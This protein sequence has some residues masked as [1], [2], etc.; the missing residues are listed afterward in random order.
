MDIKH[1]YEDPDCLHAGTLPPRSIFKSFNV[2]DNHLCEKNLNGEW[3]FSF[4]GSIRLGREALTSGAFRKASDKV[5][6]PST[7]Q[8]TGYD[9]P[10]YINTRY[11]F[12][13]NP[14][15]VPKDNPMGIYERNIVIS[16]NE[17]KGSIILRFDGVDSCFFVHVNEEFVGYSQVSHSISEFDITDKLHEGTNLLT[18]TVLKWCDGSY[19]ECQDKF[20][21]T[22]IFRDVDL[23][24][25]P[26]DYL[27]DYTVSALPDETLTHGEFTLTTDKKYDYEIKCELAFEGSV[28]ASGIVD[29]DSLSLEIDN[30][31]LWNQEEPKLYELTITTPKEIIKDYV[32]FRRID[33]KGG[34]FYLNN[35]PCKLR[36]VNYHD[37]NPYEGARLSRTQVMAD[38]KLMREC[39]INAIRTSHY[40][41]PYWFMELADRYGFAL[42]DEADIETHGASYIYVDGEREVSAL[43]RS[44]MFRTAYLDRIKLLYERD[45]NHP[46]V[47]LWSLGNESGYGENLIEGAKYLHSKHDGR[48]VH[49]EGADREYRFTLPVDEMD[50]YSNMYASPERVNDYCNNNPER[51]RR[52]YMQCEFCHAM[53]NGPGD[54]HENVNQLFDYEHYFGAFVWEWCDHAVFDGVDEAGHERFLYGGDSGEAYHDGNFCMD[55]LVFPD[56]RVHTG[57]LEYKNVLRPI[58]L[59]AFNRTS[60][61]AT[62]ENRYDYADALSQVRILYELKDAGKT[63]STGEVDL[64][65]LTAWKP[66]EK[67]TLKILNAPLE[68]TQYIIF[69]Y[70]SARGFDLLNKGFEL[71][72]DEVEP[73]MIEPPVA[74]KGAVG[75]LTLRQSDY[76]FVI[77]GDDLCY[78][79]DRELGTFTKLGKNGK[80]LITRP[81]EFNVL[82]AYTDND[83]NVRPLWEK[84]GYN[85]MKFNVYETKAENVSD[86][87]VITF[88]GVLAAVHR[89]PAVTIFGT[90]TIG[91]DGSIT[92]KTN[93]T[94]NTSMEF[95][96]R[97]GLRLFIPKSFDRVK[98]F[99]YGPN[100]SYIDKH[101]SC[102][103]DLFEQGIDELSEPYVKPQETGSHFGTH[104]LTVRNNSD[105]LFVQAPASFSFNLSHYTAE[106]Q[107]KAAHLWELEN[108]PD[109]VLCLD[110]KMSGVG[111]NSCGPELPDCYR[112]NEETFNWEIKLTPI[113]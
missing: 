42:V 16:E 58:K 60:T 106:R 2:S 49:Y 67:V 11:P 103:L 98:Y 25:R 78:V 68:G 96:P 30:P 89:S 88:Y 40:P 80:K 39:N 110:Y 15:F 92:L 56:R 73:I 109:N 93:C 21:E 31:R 101:R 51:F 38:L 44:P 100:E 102:S 48:L 69:K 37:S 17:L 35:V 107:N 82:R 83:R 66:H 81:L 5:Y 61:E 23:L 12:P 94:R 112:L 10:Q 4:Y 74:S 111:S 19:L 90:W 54:L 1:F 64:T 7:W 27:F 97:F 63:I 46:S 59:A 33:V 32:G 91:S 34:V 75:P 3:N 57:Y 62:F 70:V 13:V 104:Y 72:F 50:V 29:G 28:V 52:P 26:A 18:V 45:K 86:G 99:G 22:G 36:G 87:V 53:G 105:T 84:Y 20:R 47:L 8:H 6:V 108:E 24:I 65:G 79:F 113:L 9:K 55:G 14:P 77:T 95:L 76:E 41:K 43:S 85:D 71:G